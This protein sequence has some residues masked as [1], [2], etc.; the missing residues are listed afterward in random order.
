[1][2]IMHISS[3]HCRHVWGHDF[4][5][6]LIKLEDNKS[7]ASAD[8]SSEGLFR[9]QK[10]LMQKILTVVIPGGIYHNWV[11]V[12]FPTAVHKSL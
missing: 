3:L 5:P 6:M 9:K 12:G 4:F 11:T 8:F 1:M 7:W 2:H 10:L